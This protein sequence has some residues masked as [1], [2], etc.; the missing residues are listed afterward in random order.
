[1]NRK[2]TLM[3]TNRNLEKCSEYFDT[4]TVQYALSVHL[5][6]RPTSVK[7]NAG[8]NTCQVGEKNAKTESGSYLPNP[9]YRIS[10]ERH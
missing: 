7:Q 10:H 2:K 9:E 3:W 1:M 8:E 6:H 5:N 4:Y